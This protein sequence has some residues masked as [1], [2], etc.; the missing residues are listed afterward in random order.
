[1]NEDGPHKHI[2]LNVCPQACG[3]ALGRIGVEGWKDYGLTAGDG[4]LRLSLEISKAHVI[5]S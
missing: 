4:L 1:M 5:I 3:T 2:Y